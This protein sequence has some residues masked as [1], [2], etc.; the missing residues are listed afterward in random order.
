[1]EH[2]AAAVTR[3][4]DWVQVRE[5]ELPGAGLVDFAQGV[6]EA[7]RGAG[8]RAGRPV[9][10]IVNRRVD[11]ALAVGADGVHL[12]FDAMPPQEARRLLGPDALVGVSCH[13][14]AEV[15]AAGGASYA[16]LA[17]VFAP[18]SK[19]PSRP[20]LGLEALGVAAGARPVLAQGGVEAGNAAACLAAGAAGV[21]VTGAVL[22][23]RDPG[24]AAAA[25][26]AALDTP[27]GGRP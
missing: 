2:V 14:P 26:R 17:P 4:V 7:A 3:G 16:H 22:Q 10:V 1:M 18:L 12:G 11:V 5:R 15:G 8:A 20:P 27:P 9:K 23:A 24:Q 19:A 6:A 25:L 13:A 21:A